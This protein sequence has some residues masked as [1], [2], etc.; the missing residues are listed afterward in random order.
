LCIIRINKN[1]IVK[2]DERESIYKWI[3]RELRIVETWHEIYKEEHPGG[4]NRNS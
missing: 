3:F 4:A 1:S 2:N